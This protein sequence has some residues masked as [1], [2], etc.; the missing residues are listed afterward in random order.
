[1]VMKTAETSPGDD[2]PSVE[3]HHIRH[4]GYC[5][6]QGGPPTSYKWSYNPS[7]PFIFG[8]L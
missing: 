2:S 4:A 8:H 7:Y 5:F 3:P 1:M 6:Q